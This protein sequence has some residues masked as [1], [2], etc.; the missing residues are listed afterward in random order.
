MLVGVLWAGGPGG[1]E[2]GGRAC[3]LSASWRRKLRVPS[4]GSRE[5]H[6]VDLDHKVRD[7]LRAAHHALLE[8]VDGPRNSPS[9]LAHPPP[10][11]RRSAPRARRAT[12]RT[13]PGSAAAAAARSSATGRARG[14]WTSPAARRAPPRRGRRRRR[15]RVLLL[16]LR[17]RGVA[18][19]R[20]G[21]RGG[22]GGGG[23]LGAVGAIATE[24]PVRHRFEVAALR[25]LGA[26]R[27]S[28]AA[29]KMVRNSSSFFSV[30]ACSR[31]SPIEA[32][33]LSAM[34][35][36]G[37]S[38][39]VMASARGVAE[40]GQETLPRPSQL[41]LHDCSS[42]FWIGREGRRST[43]RTPPPPKFALDGHAAP[44][45]R[46]FELT[47]ST[48]PSATYHASFSGWAALD[49]S[50]CSSTA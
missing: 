40:S 45:L 33:L 6:L 43:G 30:A 35:Q 34:N 13:P 3:S 26:Q 21:G 44:H 37:A 20:G 23:R 49:A 47:R 8:L 41:V 28:V 15:R 27:A 4:A 12:P 48:P 31:F 2:A 17:D 7:D 1:R 14:D 42:L 11:A 9:V 50:A 39:V 19:G 24:Q 16:H 38:P 22:F 36:D 32:Q 29:G 10:T 25:E 18:V 5:V 46:S